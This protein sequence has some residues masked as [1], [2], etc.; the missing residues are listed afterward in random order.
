ML[1]AAC[2]DFDDFRSTHTNIV[3][4]IC[5]PNGNFSVAEFERRVADV[6]VVRHLNGSQT[7]G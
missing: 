1:T 2:A 7:H 6:V 3:N 5:R 4:S